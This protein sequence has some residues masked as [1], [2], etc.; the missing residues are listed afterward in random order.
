MQ[1]SEQKLSLAKLDSRNYFKKSFKKSNS[2]LHHPK[3]YLAKMQKTAYIISQKHQL[4]VL[5]TLRSLGLFCSVP[6]ADY[7]LVS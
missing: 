5:E 2:N 7:R 6:C 4:T 1:G 3:N